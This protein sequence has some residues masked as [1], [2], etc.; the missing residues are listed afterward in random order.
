MFAEAYRETQRKADEH[1]ALTADTRDY[2]KNGLLHCHKCNTPKQVLLEMPAILGGGKR[3]QHCMC[4]CQSEAE[5]LRREHDRQMRAMMLTDRLRSVS[6]MESQFQTARF[7]NFKQDA[8]NKR[9]LR[10]CQRYVEKYP[11]L[12]RKNQ[13]LLFFGAVG[14]GKSYA[15]ACIANAL[16]EMH[17]PLV[18][19]SF[20]HLLRTARQGGE[21]WD[22]ILASVMQARLLILDDYGTE[23]G[24]DTVME[25]VYGIIDDRTRSGRPMII[26]TN[27]DHQQMMTDDDIRRKRVNDRILQTCYPVQFVGASKRVEDAASRYDEMKMLLE[28]E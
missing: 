26:T 22:S 8:D 27:L 2:E 11:E 6:L 7:E 10:I 17:V 21:R 23:S 20:V 18:M 5:E 13:G 1:A 3:L 24:T 25:I 19:T 15:A 4:K 12:E 14:T 28:E 16:L 9:I